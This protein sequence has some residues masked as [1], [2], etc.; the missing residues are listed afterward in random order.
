M[1]WG[2]T[3]DNPATESSNAPLNTDQ[4]AQA[5][6][7]L[8]D[9]KE[10]TDE[11]QA[12]TAEPAAAPETEAEAQDAPEATTEDDPTVTVK[13]DGKDVEVKLSELKN[14]YQRQADYTRKTME[15]AEQRKA[16][17][18][19]IAKAVQ[20]RQTYAQNLQR[21]QAQLE[22]AL[23]EQQKSINW[24]QLLETDPQ[25]YLQERHLAEQRQAALQQ[26]YAEQQKLAAIHQA[27][28]A[29]RFQSHLQQQQEQLL[30]K[31]PEWKDEAK[32]RAAKTALRDYLLQQGY[33]EQ[34]VSSV[35][36]ARAVLLAHKAMQYDAMMAKANAAAKK[37]GT[38]PTKVERPGT[39]E[40][41]GIDRRTS[42]FQR[43]SKSG[44]VE[45]AAAVFSSLL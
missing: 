24:Q 17:E 12:D 25:R 38:L 35:A 10:Q 22:G 3:L 23:A 43:L 27:E 28:E 40:N 36:D 8:L 2:T 21:M 20:E 31:L 14:G 19:Q 1:F 33:D 41:P 16:A 4:A 6:A 5:F 44:R 26:N 37:V 11:P 13:I 42:A 9:P 7:E 39:G 34:S 32:A 15:T 45:D 18:A 29:R 30:A